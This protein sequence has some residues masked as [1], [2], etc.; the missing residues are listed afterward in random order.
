M[1]TYK[2][3]G[4]VVS[5]II[6]NNWMEMKYSIR[7][8]EV[9]YKHMENRIAANQLAL[10]TKIKQLEKEKEIL[11][12]LYL[13]REDQLAKMREDCQESLKSEGRMSDVDEQKATVDKLVGLARLL[14]D[15]QVNLLVLEA[16][17]KLSSQELKIKQLEAEN[18]LLVEIKK[19]S[20]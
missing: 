6:Y 13:L 20:V 16:V 11:E 8:L 19:R 17:K 12:N 5:E 1:N 7:L 9:N 14:S 3:F 15:E 2:I 18:K 4:E 10:N